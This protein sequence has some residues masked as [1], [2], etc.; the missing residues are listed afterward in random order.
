LAWAEETVDEVGF[1]DVEA[2]SVD[3]RTGGPVGFAG[4]S[5]ILR[6]GGGAEGVVVDGLG[7]MVAFEDGAEMDFFTAMGL[8]GGAGLA[9]EE[10][11]GVVEGLEEMGSVVGGGTALVTPVPN[12]PEF[13]IC[14][15][16]GACQKERRGRL[17]NKYLLYLRGRGT[18]SAFSCCVN[19]SGALSGRSRR[20]VFVWRWLT[21]WMV[22]QNKWFTFRL[23]RSYLL[24]FNRLRARGIL[25]F[26]V[27]QLCLVCAIR[28]MD[29]A[30]SR[31][32]FW[33]GH[34][35]EWERHNNAN[36]AFDL[37]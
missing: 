14:N 6:V 10:A 17:E 32:S 16:G 8:D 18:R 13:K 11:W 28:V 15:A 35:V 30:I 5:D 27:T 21:G 23:C 24:R 3:D 1:T 19:R 22:V 34:R 2:D 4:A 33:A 9:A 25:M 7:G 29:M 31:K 26:N 36:S 37:T 20:V 12:L